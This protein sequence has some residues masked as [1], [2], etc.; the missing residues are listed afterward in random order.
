MLWYFVRHGTLGSERNF[1][2]WFNMPIQ[3]T[4]TPPDGWKYVFFKNIKEKGKHCSRK[5][6][7]SILSLNRFKATITRDTWRSWHFQQT[8]IYVINFAL[9]PNQYVTYRFIQLQGRWNVLP[10]TKSDKS[11]VLKI[12]INK[13]RTE[14]INKRTDP[15]LSQE[16]YFSFYMQGLSNHLE[17]AV[18]IFREFNEWMNE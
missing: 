15:R 16:F 7:W 5:S 4:I 12:K 17:S 14:M 18:N 9:M 8:T 1:R 11:R 6:I 3:L 13:E 10:T 2:E